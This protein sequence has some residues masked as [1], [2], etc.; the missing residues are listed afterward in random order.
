MNMK[1]LVLCTMIV[2][3]QLAILNMEARDIAARGRAGGGGGGRIKAGGDGDGRGAAGRSHNIQRSPSM[4]RASTPSQVSRPRP[5]QQNVSAP[6]N[7]A[8]RQESNRPQTPHLQASPRVGGQSG[9]RNQVQNFVN[10]HPI[11]PLNQTINQPTPRVRRSDGQDH[12][13]HT[14]RTINEGKV[15]GGAN[16]Y[17][18]IGREVRGNLN[19]RFPNNNYNWFNNNFWN[20]HNYHPPYYYGYNDWWA[21]ATIGGVETWL[22]WQ[23][24]PYYYG[25]YDNVGY[26]TDYWG[27]FTAVDTYSPPTYYQQAPVAGT[28]AM[29]T[30]SSEWMPLGVF[31]VAKSGESIAP[32]NMFVQLA[33]NKR[34]E[35]AGTFYNTTTDQVYELEGLVD[36]AS[37]RAAWKIAENEDSPIVETGI[38]NLTASE[39]PIKVYFPDGET[40]NMLLIRLA[41]E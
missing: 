5:V 24:Q 17:N 8:R 26:P 10:K 40:Q 35:I 27:P 1:C 39:A 6:I 4:S 11:Q 38:Y 33:L 14:N 23:S 21:P 2:F 18:Q 31:A 9:A 32:A 34:G 20:R 36:Q 19:D 16:R 3:G 37:Q 41:D 12:T 25:S 15:S 7:S 22:G 30:T 13:P 29:S 28:S